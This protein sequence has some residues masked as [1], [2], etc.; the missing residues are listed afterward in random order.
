MRIIVI[1]SYLEFE[2]KG[3]IIKINFPTRY[4]IFRNEKN[5]IDSKT[6]NSFI[7]NF[8][9]DNI[10]F[11]MGIVG[12]NASGKTSLFTNFCEIVNGEYADYYLMVFEYGDGF[13]LI[14]NDYSDL[15]FVPGM[16][17][18]DLSNVHNL[19]S[20]VFLTNMVDDNELYSKKDNI[21]NLSK[22]NLIYQNEDLLSFFSDEMSRNIKFVSIFKENTKIEEYITLPDTINFTMEVENDQRRGENELIDNLV[23]LAL[24]K[25]PSKLF[26][27]VIERSK[28]VILDEL[29]EIAEYYEYI[30]FDELGSYRSF[31]YNSDN[32][33]SDFSQSLENI[34]RY[35]PLI[36]KLEPDDSINFDVSKSSKAHIAYS[37]DKEINDL[38]HEDF[39]YVDEEEILSNYS[40][41]N[42]ISFLN[43]MKEWSIYLEIMD[44]YFEN[45]HSERKITAA[46]EFVGCAEISSVTK[47]QNFLLDSP[48]WEDI[49]E[50][51]YS[52]R[53]LSS[54]ENAFLS[55]FSRLYDSKDDLLDD[56]L[57]IIDEGDMSFHPEWQQK[58]LEI[59]T[60]MIEVIF[61]NKRFQILVSTHSPFI[62]SDLPSRNIILLDNHKQISVEGLNLT[63]GSN[64]Q[65]LLTHNFFIK[66]GLTGEFAKNKINGVVDQL[67]E[68]E[69]VPEV[70]LECKKII[71]MIGEPLVRKK[72]HDIFLEKANF[73]TSMES[74]IAQL[75]LEIKKLTKK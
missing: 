20:F 29:Y 7:S 3:E 10:D 14:S 56:V 5:E 70:L 2:R 60:K 25:Y 9:S 66:S 51:F 71:N 55:I 26:K 57:L 28:S 40:I 11:V 39:Q 32:S 6:N 8:F 19:C 54:G 61:P 69:I 41:E 21:I 44:E 34:Q 62:L 50:I 22:T 16:D 58:W 47:M 33:K 27:M 68:E 36:L 72:V 15:K 31:F 38:L 42:G 17:I 52:W 23:N 59:L 13:S 49:A 37:Q 48:L 75:E 65:D 64:I 43:L 73:A 12:K 30:N 74:R 46:H 4:D 67:L 24:K 1:L 63:F 18:S 45:I 53:Q 35:L